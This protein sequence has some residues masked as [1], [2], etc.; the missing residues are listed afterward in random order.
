MKNSIIAVVL[1]TLIPIAIVVIAVPISTDNILIIAAVMIFM[2]VVIAFVLNASVGGLIREI[3]AQEGVI[4]DIQKELSWTEARL[5]EVNTLDDLTGCYN[6]NHFLDLVQHHRGMAE[7]GQ[8]TFTLCAAELDEYDQLINRVG[9]HKSDEILSLIASIIRSAVREIDIVAR[10]E[11]VQF[12]LLLAGATEAESIDIVTRVSQLISQIQVPEGDPIQ[13]TASAGVA[14]Y[15]DSGED[16]DHYGRAVKVLEYA[17][18]QGRNRVA[19]HVH[20]QDS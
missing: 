7:R 16:D 11:G 9:R 17:I 13:V 18:D 2:M 19:A 3:H 14:E 20:T 4:E 6:R 8:Y 5:E 15:C 10:I 1:T 12:A